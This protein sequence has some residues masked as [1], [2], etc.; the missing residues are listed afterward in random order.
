MF[1][2]I[3]VARFLL[4]FLALIQLCRQGEAWQCSS[5][6]VPY[7][8]RGCYGDSPARVFNVQVLNERDPRSKVYGGR[9][10][11]WSDWNRYMEGFACRCAKLVKAK[12]WTV[13]G[14]QFYG[15]CWSGPEGSY[16]LESMKQKST[17][18]SNDYKK[19]GKFDRNC[20]GEQWTNFVFELESDCEIDF[21]RIGC[22]KDNKRNPRPLPEYEMTDRESRLKI[23]SGQPI[24]WRN[25]DVYLPRFVCRCA[26][27]AKE[28]GFKTFGVQY[29]GECWSGLGGERT[30]SKLGLSGN[31]VDKCFD[32]C[33]PFEKHCSGK[34]FANAV[35]RLSDA[36]CEIPHEAVGCYGEVSYPK[37]ALP[38]ELV[39]EVKPYSKAFN[40]VIMEFGDTWKE[41]F[42]KFLCRCARKAVLKGYTLFGV[43]EHGECWSASNAEETYN[44]YGASDQCFQNFN[45]TCTAGSSTCA[46]GTNANFVYRIVMR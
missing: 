22:F 10:I 32:K 17:C 6:E 12:G 41:G 27:L 40:G 43:H 25:W 37:R 35:Y 24:D 31:C 33:K 11:D 23:Y 16:D 30:Y 34:N 21:E 13:F 14:L 5:C 44:K 1:R 46:G 7:K 38:D 8:A 19:C 28:K 26:K 4:S 42:K 39:N 9:R 29:Y 36:E 2:I 15:E 3:T 20:I 45:Q 18:I